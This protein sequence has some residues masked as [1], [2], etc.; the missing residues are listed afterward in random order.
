MGVLAPECVVGAPLLAA[1]T[2]ALAFLDTGRAGHQMP[3][4][5]AYLG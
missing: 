3:R 1:I 4:S 5:V 2:T